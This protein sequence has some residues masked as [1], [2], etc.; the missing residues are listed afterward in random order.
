MADLGPTNIEGNLVIKNQTYTPNMSSGGTSSRVVV[1]DDDGILRYKI[2]ASSSGSS[3]SGGTS[4]TRGTGGTSGSSGSGGSSG[5]SG[6]DGSSG[7]RGTGGTSGSGGSSGS[8]G[9]GGTSGSSGSGGTSGTRGTG[10]SSGSSGSSG[11]GGTS[12]T[13]GTSGTS[14]SSGTSG[15]RGPIGNSGPIGPMGIDGAVSGRWFFTDSFDINGTEHFTLIYHN[16]QDYSDVYIIHINYTTYNNI[17]FYDWLYQIELYDQNSQDIYITLTN[18][19][20]NSNYAIYKIDYGSI[21]MYGSTFEAGL[22][23]VSSNGYF[24]FPADS[25]LFS[26]SFMVCGLNGA[27]GANGTSGTSQTINTST[28][29]TISTSGV[30]Y[31]NIQL[32]NQTLSVNYFNSVHETEVHIISVTNSCYISLGSSG[33]SYKRINLASS[34]YLL[35][36]SKYILSIKNGVASLVTY[37]QS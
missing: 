10:G 12:G 21:S 23:Y 14:G 18:V 15:D 5:S 11:S 30:F 20:D 37:E 31:N 28:Y 33:G 7:T 36:G 9:S 6:S 4:G 8:S 32:N 22:I 35:A 13:R 25:E 24:Q 16:N 1:L 29:T 34:Q 27:N 3:G 17:N 2:N 19:Y 26:I